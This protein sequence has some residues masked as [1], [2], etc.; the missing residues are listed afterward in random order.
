MLDVCV[1]ILSPSKFHP[2]HL[3]KF[4]SILGLFQDGIEFPYVSLEILECSLPV[5]FKFIRTASSISFFSVA[6]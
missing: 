5:A 3:H 2:Y 6:H 1:S 4:A